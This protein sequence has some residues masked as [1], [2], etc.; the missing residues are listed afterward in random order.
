MNF[1]VNRRNAAAFSSVTTFGYTGSNAVHPAPI[2]G[3]GNGSAVTA[4]G[5][6]LL[7][8]NGTSLAPGLTVGVLG[9]SGAN[10]V[11]GSLQYYTQTYISFYLAPTFGATGPRHLVFAANNDVYVLPAGVLLVAAAPPSINWVNSVL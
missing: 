8:S 6:G 1:A 3:T 7:G 4:T 10:L 9:Q 2:L 5:T 11:A